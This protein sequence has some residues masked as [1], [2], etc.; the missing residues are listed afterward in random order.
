MEIIQVTYTVFY[1][2]VDGGVINYISK[3]TGITCFVRESKGYKK[4]LKGLSEV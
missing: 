4:H 3:R 1:P 2:N